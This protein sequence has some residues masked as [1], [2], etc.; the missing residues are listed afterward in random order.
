MNALTRLKNKLF[1][2][3]PKRLN[4][5]DYATIGASLLGIG[6]VIWLTHDILKNGWGGAYELIVFMFFIG[7][8]MIVWGLHLHHKRAMYHRARRNRQ[9]MDIEYTLRKQLAEEFAE[10]GE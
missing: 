7:N 3:N 9:I 6:D 2:Y 1:K 8:V 4:D 10:I 5:F